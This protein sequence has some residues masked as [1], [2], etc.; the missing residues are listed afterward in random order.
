MKSIISVLLLALL[1]GCS[2]TYSKEDFSRE[3]DFY[4]ANQRDFLQLADLI[5][6]HDWKKKDG[7]GQSELISPYWKRNEDIYLTVKELFQDLKIYKIHVA[8]DSTTCKVRS[9][10]FLMDK[11]FDGHYGYKI[12]PRQSISTDNYFSDKYVEFKIGENALFIFEQ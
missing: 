11:K 7:R 6:D 3:V 10:E 8:L 12:Y 1:L 4:C 9:I 5:N 2:Q